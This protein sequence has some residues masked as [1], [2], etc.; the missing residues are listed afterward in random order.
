MH[1]NLKVK[2][3]CTIAVFGGSARFTIDYYK[4]PLSKRKSNAKGQKHININQL[5]VCFLF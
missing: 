3:A 5:D 4:Y 1:F 2:L